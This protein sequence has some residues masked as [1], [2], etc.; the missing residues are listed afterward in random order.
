MYLYTEKNKIHEVVFEI[1][2]RNLGINIRNEHS[3][4]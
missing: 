2:T 4:K 3:G 1:I